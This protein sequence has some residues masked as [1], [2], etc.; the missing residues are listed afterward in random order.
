MTVDPFN[1]PKLMNREQLEYWILFGICVAGKS[2][3]QTKEKV[4]TLLADM[5]LDYYGTYQK[6]LSPFKIVSKAI[7]RGKLRLFLKR[8][9]IGQYKRIERAFMDAVNVDLDNIST[10]VLESIR[11]VG[12]KTARMVMLYYDPNADCAVLDTHILKYLRAKGIEKVPKNTPSIGKQYNRLE[13]EFQR[14]AKEEGLTV[15][16]LDTKVWKSYA[17][18]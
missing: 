3:K 14:L 2:A 18:Q 15:R 8:H 7:K 6:P 9:R 12:P 4:N 11:G 5:E 13:K 17:K 16:Q 1:I 10:E